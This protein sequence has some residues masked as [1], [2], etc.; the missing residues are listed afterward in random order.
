MT[1]N[2]FGLRLLAQPR[3]RLTVLVILAIVVLAFRAIQFATLTTQIQWGY[4][5]SAYWA[6]A[7]HLLAGEPIYARG[8]ARRPVCPAGPVPVPVPAATRG[9]GHAARGAL[10]DGL[11]SRGMGVVGARCGRARLVRAGARTVGAPR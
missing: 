2:V 11:P 5:F 3:V 6:A 1:A 7:G 8:P 9:R 4:D 10:P